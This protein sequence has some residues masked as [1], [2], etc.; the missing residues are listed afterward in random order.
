MERL[1]P[2]P[3]RAQADRSAAGID[4]ARRDGIAAL[5]RAEA[6]VSADPIDPDSS[7]LLGSARLATGDA[8]NAQRAFRVAARFGWRN[9]A[10]QAYWYEA[11]LDAGDYQVA[12]ERADALLRAHPQLVDQAELLKPLESNASARPI[13]ANRLKLRP[14]WLASYLRVDDD[15]PSDVL[16]RRVLVLSSID[17]AR[18]PLGC[19]TIAS[20]TRNLLSH[21]RRK[22]AEALW[23]AN[24]PTAKVSGYLVDP[25]FSQVLSDAAAKAPFSWRAIP[26]GDVSMSEVSGPHGTKALLISNSA[27]VAR[28]ALVQAV[29][30]SAGVYRFHVTG[31]PENPASRDK[32][33]VAWACGERVPST[34]GSNGNLLEEGQIIKVTACDRQQIA[35]WLGGNGTSVRLQSISFAK[36]G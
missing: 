35:L 18:F 16:D 13:L 23:N 30:F 31:I 28:L 17:T 15:T 2:G 24:C 29:S 1:V 6:A 32:L 33:Y 10:T 19:D 21:G 9:A 3:F 7:S 11:A 25:T 20:F 14:S 34:S 22:D 5:A 26:S 12:V 4:L 8:E 36:I 27:P